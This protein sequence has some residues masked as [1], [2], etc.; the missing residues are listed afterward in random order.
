MRQSVLN[1]MSAMKNVIE[2]VSRLC[3]FAIIF[4]L[5]QIVAAWL[6]PVVSFNDDVDLGQMI[7]YIIA[8][9]LTLGALTL[10]NR[11]L[12]TPPKP[13]LKSGNGFD[14]RWILCGVVLMITL[15]IVL[16]PLN[17]YLPDDR[18]FSDSAWTLIM[19]TIVAPVFEEILFRGKLYELL[20]AKSSPIVSALLSA[21]MFGLMHLEPVVVVEGFVVGIFLSYIY[22][23]TKSIFAPIILHMCNNTLAYALKI[24]SYSERPLLDL[25]DS[26][27]YYILIYAASAAVSA[28]TLFIALRYLVRYDKIAKR[29]EGIGE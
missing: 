5:M 1:S 9:M 24:L 26:R 8:M 15:S 16:A 13:I 22:L 11:V 19:V 10:S 2:I 25:V 3:L 14:P 23:R 27:E 29:K 4:L 20:R 6:L 21:L 7:A 17:N 18:E 12:K 28:L